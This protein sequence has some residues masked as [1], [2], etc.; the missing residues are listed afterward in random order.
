MLRILKA[1]VFVLVVLISV[2]VGT[3]LGPMLIVAWHSVF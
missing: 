2:Y 3:L 1:I